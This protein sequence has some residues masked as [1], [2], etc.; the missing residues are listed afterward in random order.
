MVNMAVL[1]RRSNK[2]LQRLQWEVQQR[3]P[4][5]EQNKGFVTGYKSPTNITGH[6]A[7]VNGI[8]HAYDC[9]V[10]IEGDGTGITPSAAAWLC[11]K[12]RVFEQ[13]AH[14]AGYTGMLYYLIYNRRICGDFSDWDWVPYGGTSPHR[15]HIHFST[16]DLY[17]GDPAPVPAIT[18]D[19]TGSWGI[20]PI[21][22]KPKPKPKPKDWF[23][24]ANEADLERVVERV[25]TKPAVMD[26]FALHFLHR[27]CYL[28]DPSGE[29]GEIVGT[30]N[31]ATKINWDAHNYA[32]ILNAIVAVGN[33]MGAHMEQFQVAH[34]AELEAPAP[35]LEEAAP[36]DEQVTE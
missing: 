19:H 36:A 13:K 27:E 35:P 24:M 20:W 21:T 28:V 17:W 6:N 33:Q 18:Y 1:Y 29:T 4:G 31:H 14:R 2:S 23:A 11:E 10:D 34:A 22:E 25:I 30:T 16:C 15:D 9:G 7:D 5:R 8:T 32:Q 26:K 12:I 3:W